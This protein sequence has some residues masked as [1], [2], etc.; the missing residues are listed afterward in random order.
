MSQRKTI[1]ANCLGCDV[2]DLDRYQST[3][4]SP[5]IFTDG[6]KYFTALKA[7]EHPAEDRNWKE[8][9]LWR[10]Q[11]IAAGWRVCSAE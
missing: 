9:E 7:N 1:V 6:L 2:A 5:P 4:L 3:K 11:D 8:L 10:K